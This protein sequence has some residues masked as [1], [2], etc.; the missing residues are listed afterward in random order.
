KEVKTS[1]PSTCC[2]WQEFPSARLSAEDLIVT[3]PLMKPRHYSISSAS[4]VQPRQMNLTVGVLK[5]ING[6]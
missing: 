2:Q 6:M 5:V 1:Y 3:L 4:E